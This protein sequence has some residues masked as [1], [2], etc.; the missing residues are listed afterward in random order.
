MPI[1]A[2][3]H[4]IGHGP[5]SHV[6]EPIGKVDHNERGFSM[7]ESLKDVIFGAGFDYE[8]IKE[9]FL[10]NDS[11]SKAVKDKNLGM[12]KLDYLER[13]A[14]YTIGEKP[15]VEY[16]AHHVYLV[17]D[18]IVIN[19]NAIDQAKDI[20]DFYIKM[21]KHVYKEAIVVVQPQSLRR[22]EPTDI[23]V[24]M[25]NGDIEKISLIYPDHFQAMR[26]YGRSHL[27]LRI[28]TYG[29]YRKNLSDE[30]DKIREYILNL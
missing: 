13:D 10:E 14:Y 26:E 6:T 24:Y 23:N 4:D 29:E 16:L 8:M 27:S 20:Q 18:Q 19:E 28:C 30:S 22:F 25:Q 3:Y 7:L 1:F 11:L 21:Y 17:N 2:L 15:G 5:F 12:E 9:M